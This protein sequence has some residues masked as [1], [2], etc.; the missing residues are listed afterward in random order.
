MIQS[1]ISLFTEYLNNFDYS[2]KT[3][4]RKDKIIV[5]IKELSKKSLHTFEPD[6][7]LYQI[8][9]RSN[10]ILRIQK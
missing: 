9:L 5:A 7:Y 6:T 1:D 2:H 4:N 3:F 8:K 10:H